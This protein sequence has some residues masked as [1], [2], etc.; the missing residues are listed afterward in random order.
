M[1]T[2][3]ATAFG[4]E[5]NIQRGESDELTKTAYTISQ[6]MGEGE[7]T[8]REMIYMIF[9][10]LVF[11]QL[12]CVHESVINILYCRQSAM[13]CSV[14]TAHFC[15]LLKRRPLEVHE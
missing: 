15:S 14:G 2:I 7:L 13:G 11:L 12:T 8:S 9:S 4:R 5:V 10:E 3:L 1:E 6:L